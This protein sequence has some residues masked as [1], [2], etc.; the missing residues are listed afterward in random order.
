MHDNFNR[1]IL[2]ID[3]NRAI[4]DDFRKILSAKSE[5]STYGEL[6]TDLFGESLEKN[7]FVSFELDGAYQGREGLEMMKQSLA[8]GRPYGVAFIDVR[9]PPGWDGIETTAKL[10]EVCPELQVVICTAY[11]DYDWNGITRKLGQTDRLLIL[12]KPFDTV[13]VLQMAETLAQKWTLARQA[14]LRLSDLDAMVN[15]RT[16]ELR[17][18]NEQLA[19]FSSLGSLLSAAR[20]IR[21][22]SKI[23]VDA[24]DRLLGWDACLMDLY[25]PDTGTLTQVLH[26]D[27]MDGQRKEC[28]ADYVARSP[29]ALARKTLQEGGQLVLK[30]DP[31]RMRPEGQPFG[32]TSRPSASILFVPIRY[33]TTVIGILSIQSYTPDAYDQR[34]LETLQA[35]ADH[36]GGALDRIRIEEDLRSAQEQLRQSQKLES[37]G[38]LAGGV[39]HDFNNLLTV[40]TG[41]ADMARMQAQDLSGQVTECLDQISAA[42][43]RAAKLT[44]QLLA[45]SRKQMLQSQPVNLDDAI[46]NLS[47]M[48]KRIIGEHIDLQCHYSPALPLVRADIGM[49]EQVLVNLAVN[50]RDA[51]PDGGQL[52]ITTE[53]IAFESGRDPSHP[54]GRPGD[55][56]CT[57]VK[58]TGTGISPEILPRLFEPFFTTKD[59]GKGTGL[60]LATVYGILKQHQGWIEVASQIGAG[61]S[62]KFYLPSLQGASQIPNDPQP[63]DLEPARGTE[64]ILLVEDEAAVRSITRLILERYGYHVLEAGSAPEALRIWESATQEVDL[65]LTDV[66]MPEGVT[67][68]K[69]AEELREKKTSLKV[70][71]QSGYG[72]E[73]MAGST[74]FLR[75]SHSYF[76][77]KPCAPRVLLCAVRRCLD[78]LPAQL[79][80]FPLRS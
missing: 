36:C 69:L 78:G 75:K 9:M 33:R 8:V 79:E 56:V 25:S 3:D 13:E 37:I 64:T 57:T 29:S 80:H 1:R 52:H 53:K 18:S 43:D 24:A 67:G 14:R 31:T 21:E 73:V 49:L 48:L 41:N 19:A 58:D 40:I 55:F 54:E 17:A 5:G 71:F 20:T 61:S 44:R 6:R 51:M 32:D 42:S 7:R 59:V 23:I 16:Q 46:M 30:N 66:V 4:H 63:E 77:Q 68:R 62:F 74:D 26:A 35:L 47:K 12:K 10:W 60:G 22:A 45:F 65:L 27:V 72:T 76:L 11:S 50:A 2:V 38:Q 15:Q 70:I 28:P 39:A 34:S